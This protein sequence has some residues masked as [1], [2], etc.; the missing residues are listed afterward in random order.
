[1]QLPRLT[2][3]R[4]AGWLVVL[5]VV[6]ILIAIPDPQEFARAHGAKQRLSIATGGTGGVWY[7]YGGGVAQLITRYVPDVEATAEVTAASIDNLK[8]LQLGRVDLAFSIAD[9]L[10]EA[11]LGEGMFEVFGKVPVRTLAVLYPHPVQLVTV[12]GTGIESLEDLRGRIVSIG[13]PGSGTELL[14]IRSLEA[15]GI[16]VATDIRAQGLSVAE[17]VN[18]LRDGKIDA[19]FWNSGLPA[20]AVLDL[21]TSPGRK[22]K[23]LPTDH[24]LPEMQRLWGEQTYFLSEVPME[25]YPGMTEDVPTVGVAAILVVAED[26]DEDLAYQITRAMFEHQPELLAIHPSAEHLVPESAVQGSPAPFHPGAIRYYRE[27]GAWPQ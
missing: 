11:Y 15:G 18:A 8:L 27:V 1:M 14:A 26:L 16:S 2:P 6:A 10:A 13:A 25:T 3:G 7:P 19:F 22:M 9:A 4:I 5:A 12:E 24:I 21:A 17:S 20:G 23:M